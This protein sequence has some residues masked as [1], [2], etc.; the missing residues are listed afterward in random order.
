M[1]AAA[2]QPLVARKLLLHAQR[3]GAPAADVA[4]AIEAAAGDELPS[5]SARRSWRC[6]HW[7]R[8]GT[9]WL[10][11]RRRWW[12]SPHTART[13]VRRIYAK[14]QVK[15]RG[16]A[17]RVAAHQGLL[18][19]RL[20]KTTWNPRQSSADSYCFGIHQLAAGAGAAGVRGGAAGPAPD[21]G[22]AVA[23]ALGQLGAAGHADA[24]Q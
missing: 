3:G 18:D 2:D 10:R 12:A 21:A 9:R 11:W 14:L 20:K 13:F 19:G 5:L 16:E 22:R 8:A 23:L 1:P 24:Q 7:C 6:C 4:E 15:S 17:V